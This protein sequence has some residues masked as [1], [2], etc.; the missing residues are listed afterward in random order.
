MVR[1][2]AKRAVRRAKKEAD[3]RWG[4]KLVEDF[5]S[6]KRMFWREVKRTRKGPEVKEQ[7][8]NPRSIESSGPYRD[9]IVMI[10][11]MLGPCWI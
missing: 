4:E 8:V 9:Y 1:N 11:G 6:N 10:S 5:S 2:E 7:C 3:V